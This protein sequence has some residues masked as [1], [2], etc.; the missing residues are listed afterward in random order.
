LSML[1]LNATLPLGAPFRSWLFQAEQETLIIL[2]SINCEASKTK[3]V[4]SDPLRCQR[5]L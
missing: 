3:I 5:E 1:H 4:S 2:L